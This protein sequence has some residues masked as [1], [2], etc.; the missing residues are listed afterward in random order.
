M[1]D[2]SIKDAQILKI[3]EGWTTVEQHEALEGLAD[4]ASLWEAEGPAKWW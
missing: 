4:M 3:C 2:L 1:V